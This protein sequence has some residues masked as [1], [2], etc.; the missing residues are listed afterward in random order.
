MKLTNLF[1]KAATV[2]CALA[3]VGMLAACSNGSSSSSDDKGN[4]SGSGSG[5]GSSSSKKGDY[6]LMYDDILIADE[7]PEEY[8][9]MTQEMLTVTTDY[10]MSGKTMKL[11]DT[12]F[13]K[14]L[15]GMG[16]SEGKTYVAIIVY[17]KEMLMPV[18]ADDLA[19]AAQAGLKVG[20]DYE[21][22]HGGKV[23]ELTESGFQKGAEL[24][25]DDDDDDDSEQVMG[26]FN[27]MYD[28]ILLLEKG[29]Q[30]NFDELK[31]EFPSNSYT[32]KDKTVTLNNTGLSKF[33]E[34]YA[35]K[36]KSPKPYVAIIVYEKRMLMPVT[37]EMMEYAAG[38]LQTPAD[39]TLTHNDKVIELTD[40]GYVNGASLFSN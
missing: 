36:A 15:A 13:T 6:K 18:T 21:L 2:L 31:A 4:G 19:K 35:K 5:G 27:L 33:L 20:T 8:M 9:T 12:G 30:S 3:L 10:T 28:D 17:K 38:V 14:V 26:G 11:T 16:Q 25:G 40:S 22:T 29:T 32:V 24:F 23:I 7:W 37:E 34:Y 1:K 39:Y